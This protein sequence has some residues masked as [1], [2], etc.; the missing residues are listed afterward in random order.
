MDGRASYSGIFLQAV[1]AKGRVAIPSNFR[2]AMERNSAEKVLMLTIHGKRPCLIGYDRGWADLRYRE[3]K[4]RQA[5]AVA[6]GHDVDEDDPA[7][8]AFELSEEV[9]YDSSGRFVLPSFYRAE[10]GLEGWAVFRGRTENFQ[11]WNPHRLLESD[12]INENIKKKV[13]HDFADRGVTLQ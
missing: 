8:D 12:E 2:G 10:A 4:Q 9:N 1:D 7:F 13:R 11:I 3:I 6:Q 5:Q